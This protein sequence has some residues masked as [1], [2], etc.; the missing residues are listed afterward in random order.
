VEDDIPIDSEALLV[1]NF[2]NLKIKLTQSFGG[3][4]MIRVCMCMFIEVNTR[5]CMN[6]YVFTVFLKEITS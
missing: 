5:T 4:H 1:T 6:I 3:D 2:V